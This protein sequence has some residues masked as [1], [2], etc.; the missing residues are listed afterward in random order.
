MSKYIVIFVTT[1]SRKEAKKI[2]KRILKEKLAACVNIIPLV[3]SHYWWKGKIECSKE[4]LLI[5]K[6]KK[7]LFDK[8]KKLIK[9]IHSYTVPE[10]IALPIILGNTEYL[11]WIDEVVKW[12]I[13]R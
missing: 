12:Q 3:E 7:E 2:T 11:N 13:R 8:L 1:G 9:K 10:I 5:I 6:T 4:T